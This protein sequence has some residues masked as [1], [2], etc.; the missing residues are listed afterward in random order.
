MSLTR[1]FD[2]L[3]QDWRA[4]LNRTRYLP[5]WN[6]STTEEIPAFGVVTVSTLYLYNGD[7]LYLAVK[8]TTAAIESGKLAF[9]GPHPI[10]ANARGM[11]TFETPAIALYDSD[12]PASN[13]YGAEAGEW[14]LKAGRPGFT[15]LGGA[16][17]LNLTLSGD[18][19]TITGDY[20]LVHQANQV[21]AGVTQMQISTIDGDYLAC[22]YYQDGTATDAVNVA[23]NYKL[24]RTPFDTL[25]IG[26]ITYTYTSD[27]QRTA[28]GATTET[29]V[30]V[31]AYTVG[32]IIYASRVSGLDVTLSSLPL[33][34][35][36]VNADGRAWAKQ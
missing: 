30:V 8:P 32:D 28:V 11:F 31:P 17:L 23:K 21:G 34:W 7:P 27:T 4:H 26:G 19:E 1:P 33:E 15:K 20:V 3:P 5:C 2:P 29:Q 36:D 22:N 12:D 6:T 25:T 9:C 13:V 16:P 18:P 14:K 10:A 24:R 35:V